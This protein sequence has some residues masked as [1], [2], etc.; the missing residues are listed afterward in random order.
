MT[1]VGERAQ[2]KA[3]KNTKMIQQQKWGK[4]SLSL[5][6]QHSL[7]T[8]K[9]SLDKLN[10]GGG[11]G[12]KGDVYR[13]FEWNAHESIYYCKMERIRYD[14]YLYMYISGKFFLTYFISFMKIFSQFIDELRV[15]SA[16]ILLNISISMIRRYSSP[17]VLFYDVQIDRHRQNGSF[18]KLS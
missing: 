11:G 12:C 18:S 4:L 7:L 8:I 13:K 15:F 1:R 5:L 17:N 3:V 16:S 9:R 10:W 2:K 6:Q 14:K